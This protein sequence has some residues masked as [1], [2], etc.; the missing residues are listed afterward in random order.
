MLTA[1]CGPR[2]SVAKVQYPF[3]VFK[4]QLDRRDAQNRPDGTNRADLLNDPKTPTAVRDE[5]RA[6][7]N[8]SLETVA[9][10]AARNTQ[11]ERHADTGHRKARDRVMADYV[12][13]K[14]HEPKR[15]EKAHPDVSIRQIRKWIAQLRKAATAKS[16]SKPTGDWQ[17]VVYGEMLRRQNRLAGR[18]PKKPKI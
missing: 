4:E 10:I 18:R 17:R 5:I 15:L 14:R 12:P 8:H 7:I 1:A 9:A 3:A 11:Q 2:C 6:D 16:T 13:G